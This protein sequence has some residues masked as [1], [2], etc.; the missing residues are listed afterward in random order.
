MPNIHV[1]GEDIVKQCPRCKPASITTKEPN[2]DSEEYR[3]PVAMMPCNTVGC[4]VFSCPLCRLVALN[5]L[6][7]L[8]PAA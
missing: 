1:I 2:Q 6:S 3:I 8:A 7:S 5:V 4:S